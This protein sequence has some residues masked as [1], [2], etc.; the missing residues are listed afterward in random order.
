MS[1]PL[2]G[3]KHV[4]EACAERFYDLNRAPAVCFKCGAEQSPPKPRVYRPLRAS[5]DRG[6]FGRYRPTVMAEKPEPAEDQVA[7]IEEADLADDEDAVLDDEAEADE[8]EVEIDPD[9]DKSLA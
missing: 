7:E 1:N 4:C 6:G 9:D 8:V 2:F 5:S 3:T